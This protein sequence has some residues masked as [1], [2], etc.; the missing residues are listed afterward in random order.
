[1]NKESTV[2]TAIAFIGFVA[3]VI[4]FIFMIRDNVNKDQQKAQEKEEAEVGQLAN[5]NININGNIYV[6]KPTSSKAVENFIEH[7]PF[8]VEMK[9]DSN[10][11]KG[12]TY[13]KLDASA[14]RIKKAYVGDVL[15]EGN[16]TI[17]IVTNAFKTS[18]KYTVI[19]HI[20][21]V[22]NIPTGNVNAYISK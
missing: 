17:M 9:D 3:I 6:V 11:K 21:D 12:V 18:D 5:F 7:L 13:F 4:F 15:L 10:V 20:D 2:P 22:S 19:G 16:S 1:M 14:K 8:E